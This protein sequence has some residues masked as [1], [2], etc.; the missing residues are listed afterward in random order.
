MR[1]AK[2]QRERER[3][4]ERGKKQLLRPRDVCMGRRCNSQSIEYIT[5]DIHY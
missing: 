2:R 5:P 1:G 4:R 3:E